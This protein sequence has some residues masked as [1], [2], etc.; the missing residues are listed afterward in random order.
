[1][2]YADREVSTKH[3]KHGELKFTV[4]VPQY[5]SEA[6]FGAAVPAEERLKFINGNVATGAVNGA[7]AYARGA[8]DTETVESIIE[9]SKAVAKGYTPTGGERGPSKKEKVAT[10]DSLAQRIRDAAAG[11]GTMPTEAELLAMAD[12]FGN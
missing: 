6:E 4:A 7:R 10:L 8:A 2:R 12:K 9:K 1:M 3:P 5:D 11:K